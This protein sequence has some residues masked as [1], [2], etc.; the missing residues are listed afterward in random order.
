MALVIIMTSPPT[1]QWSEPMEELFRKHV[2]RRVCD[3]PRTD[4]DDGNNVSLGYPFTVIRDEVIQKGRADFG[5]PHRNSKYGDLTPEDKVLLYCF[6]NM[7]LHFFEALQAF[8]HYKSK[9]QELFSSDQR[10]VIADLGCGPGTAGLALSDCLKQPKLRYIGLDIAKAMRR[11][12]RNMLEAAIEEQLL[13]DGSKIRTVASWGKLA[14][15]PSRFKKT[16][17][18]LF[19]ATYLFSSDSLS[20]DDVCNAVM[21]FKNSSRVR[22]LLFVYSNT[23]ADAAN[24]KFVTFKTQLQNEFTTDGLIEATG[25]YHKKRDNQETVSMT[26]VHELLDFKR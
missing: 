2:L 13:A 17:D 4:W 14:N 6:A 15:V 26:F 23:R 18:V 20:V 8:G 25:S 3:D 5:E 11:K 16:K 24:A 19:N 22:R 7:R 12:A 21:A 1:L 10:T 9:L